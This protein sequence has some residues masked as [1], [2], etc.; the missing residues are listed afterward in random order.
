MKP[1]PLPLPATLYRVNTYLQQIEP[2]EVKADDLLDWRPAVDGYEIY[3]TFYSFVGENDLW[4]HLYF[5]SEAKRALRG[6]IQAEIDNLKDII[7]RQEE[8]LSRI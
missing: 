5:H 8:T 7:H 1:F 2:V 3:T 6:L 4:E